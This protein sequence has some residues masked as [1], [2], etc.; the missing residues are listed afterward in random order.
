MLTCAP[1]CAT[2]IPRERNGENSMLELKEKWLN[3]LG[4][5]SCDIP[6]EPIKFIKKYACEDFDVELYEQKN[7]PQ[8]IQRVMLAIP[9]ALSAPCPA[10]VIPYYYP[11]GML[12]FNPETN[13]KCGKVFM[14]RDL[15]KRGY[16]TACADAYHLTYI[17]NIHGKTG[18]DVWQEAGEEL[19][20]DNPNWTGMGKLVSDTKLLIDAVD[21]DQRVDSSRIGIA[22]HSLG[23]K[24]AFYTGCLDERIKV[25]VAS[26]FGIGW[27]QTNWQDIWYWHDK[28]E[29]FIQNGTDHSELLSIANKPFCLIAGQYDDDTSYAIMQKALGKAELKFINH[30]TGHFPPE[31]ALEQAYDFI[32]KWL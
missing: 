14:M 6:N 21:A 26:D 18:L 13:E 4:T 27:K 25:I 3:A 30:A 28:V 32:D 5:P 22:G 7:G 23:G 9:K 16:I 2:I 24:M 17:P 15:T 11:E 20:K 1:K 29:E 12:G 31:G 19:L 10:V 8:T